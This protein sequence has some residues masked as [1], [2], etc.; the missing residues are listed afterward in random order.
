M[1]LTSE[2]FWPWRL[3]SRGKATVAAQIPAQDLY[4]AMIKDTISPALRAEG[5]I[6]S[7]GR[8]SVRS[9][10]HWALVGFQKSAYSDR[11]EIQFTVNLMV[12]RRDE[13]LAQAAE[14]SSFPV[15]PSAS[16]GYGSVMPKR[17]GSLVGDGADKWWRLFGGQDVDLLAADVL[18]DLRDAGLPWLRERV[19]ATS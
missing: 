16:L 7:G 9:D 19:A 6:G 8:Y 15:K 18:T 13:W 14:D 5:L 3:R 1:P 2:S 12:V 10:T 17:I 4:A 11:R